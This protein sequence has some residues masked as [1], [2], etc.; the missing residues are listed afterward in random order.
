MV[1]NIAANVLG[2]KQELEGGVET[3]INLR[4]HLHPDYPMSQY[5]CYNIITNRCH[6]CVE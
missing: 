6:V 5:K 1:N 3:G 4:F 2:S